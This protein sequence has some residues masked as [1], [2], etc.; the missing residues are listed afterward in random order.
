ML[1]DAS[2]KLSRSLMLSTLPFS[3]VR[4]SAIIDV[5]AVRCCNSRETYLYL[6]TFQEELSRSLT[7]DMLNSNQAVQFIGHMFRLNTFSSMPFQVQY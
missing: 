3:A 2:Q 1:D 6:Q 4:R 7:A 5:K